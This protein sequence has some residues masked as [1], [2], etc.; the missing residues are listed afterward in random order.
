VQLDK[1]TFRFQPLTEADIPMLSD[2]LNRPHVAECWGGCNSVEQ[3]RE[4]YLPRMAD[5]STMVPYVAFRDDIPVGY[6]QSYVPAAA[7]DG[8]WPNEHDPGVR[9]VDQFLTD[10]QS[11]GQG[12]GA[13]MIREF[14]KFLF[15]DPAVTKIQ[16]DP[17]PTNTRA[18][19]CY[20][21]A[22]F[23]QTGQITTPDGAAVLM[24]IERP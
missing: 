16:A 17:A 8:W 11:L 1:M 2:W 5:G 20:E 9:G 19:R 13:E 23:L 24:I 21:K 10:A 15:L 6:I 7:T 12:L 3:V 14:V 4:I 22:G 18:I